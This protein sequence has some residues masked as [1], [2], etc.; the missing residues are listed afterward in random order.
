MQCGSSSLFDG[1]G[2][3]TTKVAALH[4]FNKLLQ[5]V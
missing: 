1:S 2:M 3:A 5:W 4:L